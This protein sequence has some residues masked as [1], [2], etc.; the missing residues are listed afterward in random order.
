MH[1]LG[2]FLAILGRVTWTHS[3]L[4]GGF[5]RA[6]V[7][8]VMLISAGKA[9]LFIR[10]LSA[11]LSMLLSAQ[12]SGWRSLLCLLLLSEAAAAPSARKERLC[13]CVGVIQ[14]RSWNIGS[15]T[16]EWLL[17]LFNLIISYLESGSTIKL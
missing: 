7:E 3:R 2:Y 4:L 12:E 5:Y 15:R 14:L 8:S 6:T 11:I 9:P 17:I 16:C 10:F 13:T 1:C